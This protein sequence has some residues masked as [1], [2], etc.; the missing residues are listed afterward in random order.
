MFQT[1]N[2]IEMFCNSKR[3]VMD[4]LNVTNKNSVCETKT[5]MTLD[6]FCS[7]RNELDIIFIVSLRVFITRT[8]EHEIDVLLLKF[9]FS[10]LFGFIISLA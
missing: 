5:M 9:K 1:L 2:K 10:Y 4:Y 7:K 3:N 6:N 8:L